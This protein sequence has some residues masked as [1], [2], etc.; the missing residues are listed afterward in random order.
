MTVLTAEFIKYLRYT[1]LNPRDS[2][3]HF[4]HDFVCIGISFTSGACAT[5]YKD[6]SCTL[7]QQGGEQL[8][9]IVLFNPDT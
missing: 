6:Q 3:L 1:H 4:L 9:V 7:T 8:G 2:L 5:Q